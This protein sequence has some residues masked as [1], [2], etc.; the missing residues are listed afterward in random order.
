MS[1]QSRYRAM[2]GEVHASADLIGKVKGIPMEKTKKRGI[3]LRLATATCAGLLGVFVVTNGVCY[4]ATGETWVEKATVW[5]N[6]EPME[7]DVQMQQDGDTVVGTIEY[8]AEDADGTGGD[9]AITMSAE[10]GDFSGTT[11]EIKDYTAEGAGAADAAGAMVL[12][13]DDGHVLLAP[14]DGAAVEPIDITDQLAAKGAA[15]GTYEANGI[16]YVYQVSGEP[17]NWNVNVEAQ[18]DATAQ[19]TPAASVEAQ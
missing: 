8:T 7:M 5:V 14:G 16:T 19:A 4:A 10:G 17:G 11:Y 12:E 1:N 15:T 13:S 2:M 3:A 9:V 6:G 18:G